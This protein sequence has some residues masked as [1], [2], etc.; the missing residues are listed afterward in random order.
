[1]SNVSFK[2][3]D[4]KIWKNPCN[5]YVTLLESMFPNY[6][7][8]KTV[9]VHDNLKYYDNG[10]LKF[11]FRIDLKTGAYKH[12]DVYLEERVRPYLRIFLKNNFVTKYR[13]Y[14]F[15]SWNRNYDVIIGND[16][17]PYYTIEYFEGKTRY[18]DFHHQSGLLFYNENQFLE[19]ML[20][21]EEKGFNK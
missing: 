3:L 18:I 14:E 1:M 11:S 20:Q 5:N 13:Y 19:Y 6:T 16:F 15:N 10:K 7:S 2:E 21:K 8:F 12:I 17:V 9:K 4:N